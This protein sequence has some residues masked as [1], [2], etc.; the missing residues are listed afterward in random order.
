MEENVQVMVLALI[1]ISIGIVFSQMGPQS[2]FISAVGIMFIMG[3]FVIAITAFLL[4]LREWIFSDGA[5]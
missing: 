4:F 5:A 2:P 1:A 3:A